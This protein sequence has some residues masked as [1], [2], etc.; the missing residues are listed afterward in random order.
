MDKSEATKRQLAVN[1][2]GQIVEGDQEIAQPLSSPSQAAGHLMEYY[3]ST[4]HTPGH[5][6]DCQ[7]HRTAGGF[8]GRV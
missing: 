8:D 3:L 1:W 5:A 4:R 6:P 7:Q 2:I